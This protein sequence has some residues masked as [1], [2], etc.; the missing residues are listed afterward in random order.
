MPA[1]LAR[2]MV[3]LARPRRK[4]L[5][6]DQCCGAG[7]FLIEAGLLGCRVLGFDA[8]RR[9]AK[10]C[11]RNLKAYNIDFEGVAVA[12]AKNLPLTSAGCIVTDPPYGRSASTLGSTTKA[13]VEDFLGK[14]SATAG[15]GELMCIASP[16][17]VQVGEIAQTHKVKH[18]ES[19]FV[20]VHRSLTREIAVLEKL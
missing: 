6:M 10:G 11:L 12:D 9:M 1:K 13:I 20:H 7:S 3:N 16:K 17:T 19:H 4:D 8:K 14:W 5:L 15:K 2:C 18:V